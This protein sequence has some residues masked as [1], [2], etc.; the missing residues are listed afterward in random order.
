MASYMLLG[1]PPMALMPG[2][3]WQHIH[4][5]IYMYIYMCV[6][7]LLGLVQGD[8]HFR[9]CPFLDASMPNPCSH[10]WS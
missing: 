1:L 7:V 5:H 10:R 3:E 9:G 2:H 6:F 4:T 8:N